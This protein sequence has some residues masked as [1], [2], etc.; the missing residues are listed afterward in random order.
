MPFNAKK[1]G[2]CKTMQLFSLI[3]YIR[4][5]YNTLCSFC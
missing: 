1:D 2:V 5:V 4:V 3:H